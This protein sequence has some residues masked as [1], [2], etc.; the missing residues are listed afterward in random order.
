MPNTILL[1]GDPLA[2]EGNVITAAITP[3]MAVLPAGNNVARAGANVISPSFA[4]ENEIVGKGIDDDYAVG[5][6]CLY[7]T[8]R[9]G[10][11]FYAIL[12]TAQ[13]IAAGASLST[14]ANGVL[15]A[16]TSTNPTVARALEAVTTTG[17]VARIKVEVV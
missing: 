12:G 10:D 15:V 7:W 6:R 14:G 16:Q 1:R 11:W 13:N 3:G 2:S 8:P 4:R 9:K 5:E 17:A